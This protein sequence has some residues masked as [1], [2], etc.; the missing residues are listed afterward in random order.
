[1][2]LLKSSKQRK[3]SRTT[4]QVS[5]TTPQR[6]RSEQFAPGAAGWTGRLWRSTQRFG[7][8]FP[9]FCGEVLEVRQARRAGP[10]RD[11]EQRAKAPLCDRL[12]QPRRKRLIGDQLREIEAP[13]KKL[14]Q[15]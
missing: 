14:R 15:L 10:N 1:M 9:G 13:T 5:A 4:A 11:S 6:P 12:A 3:W 8:C 2:V 7:S